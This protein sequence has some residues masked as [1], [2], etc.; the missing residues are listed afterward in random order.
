MRLFPRSFF[1]LTLIACLAAGLAWAQTTKGK[2]INPSDDDAPVILETRQGIRVAFV[3]ATAYNL[4]K[5]YIK[6]SG[7]DLRD[8]R[9]LDDYAA[10]NFCDLY[11]SY[12]QDEFAW[13]EA[14]KAVREYILQNIDNFP[15][16]VVFSSRIQLD[17]YDF[18]LHAFK[19]A[20]KSVFSRTGKFTIK[21]DF[22]KSCG[23]ARLSRIPELYF[24]L[25]NNPITLDSLPIPEEAAYKILRD[26][27]RNGN[28]NRIL[29]ISF[30]IHINDFVPWNSPS[31]PD[32]IKRADVRAILF[33]LRFYSDEN[34]TKMV[35]E[36]VPESSNPF[37]TPA[38]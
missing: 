4:S 18:G 1:A 27:E 30:F 10:L 25:L 14:R 32:V 20:E 21:A 8:D 3:P 12:Y 28:T 15:E 37:D 5:S 36:Y 11:K 26:M 7:V 22:G 34:R 6:L 16:H 35:Y 24:V 38:Q 17:R 31:E 29:Y 9:L 13:R 23:T 33:S 19:L 2:K